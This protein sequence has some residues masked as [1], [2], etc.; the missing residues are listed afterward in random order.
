MSLKRPSNGLSHRGLI[1]SVVEHRSLEVKVRSLIP[2]GD[3][4]L[5]LC[6]TLVTKRKTYLYFTNEIKTC[7]LS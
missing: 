4:E 1:S 6:P 3:L 2:N 5:F 7:H